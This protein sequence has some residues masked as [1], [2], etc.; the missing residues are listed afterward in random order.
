MTGSWISGQ[1][2]G[3]TVLEGSVGGPLHRPGTSVISTSRSALSSRASSPAKLQ[4]LRLFEKA[5]G[6][7]KAF[8]K[9]FVGCSG[10]ADKCFRCKSGMS[11]A[12]WESVWYIL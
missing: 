2:V 6:R 11:S 7:R 8:T 4:E 9:L 3:M 1:Y 12:V 5:I 10:G